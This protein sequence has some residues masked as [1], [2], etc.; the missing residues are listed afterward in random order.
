MP[1]FPLFKTFSCHFHVKVAQKPKYISPSPKENLRS[2]LLFLVLGGAGVSWVEV[3]GVA[4][5]G[6]DDP[7]ILACLGADGA[8]D[9]GIVGGGTGVCERGASCTGVCGRG[10]SCTGV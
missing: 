6:E 2:F 8:D 1:F 9:S 10:A 5:A 3:L 4:G 7:K